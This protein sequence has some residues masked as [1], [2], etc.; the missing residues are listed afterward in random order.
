MDR[1]IGF[2]FG[3]V[4]RAALMA[5]TLMGVATAASA[6]TASPAAPSGNPVSPSSG[7]IA[8]FYGNIAPF[9]GNISPFYGNIQPF[10]GNIQPFSGN[11][12]PFFGNISPF[13]GNIQPFWG[14]IN[15]YGMVSGAAS[16]GAKTFWGSLTPYVG[17]FDPSFTA[18]PSYASVAQFRGQMG[19]TWNQLY[20]SWA[21]FQASPTAANYQAVANLINAQL[22]A[23]SQA[24]FGA[25][26]RAKT[27]LS[28]DSGFVAPMLAKYHIDPSDLASLQANSVANLA[29]F[30][31][32]WNDQLMQYSGVNQVDYWMK[33]DNWSPALTQ[34]QGSAVRATVGLLDFTV[35]N[36]VTV[37]KNLIWYSGVSSFTNGHGADVASLISAAPTGQ[38]VMGIAPGA[39]VVAY[40]PFDSSGTTNWA[41]VQT[42]V[43]ALA[44]HGAGVINASLGVPN[45]TLDQGWNGVLSDPTVQA[46]TRNTILVV[47]AGNGG[48][49]QTQNIVWNGANA[50][51]IVVGSVGITGQ[52]SSFS[53]T[54][55]NACLTN[56]AGFCTDYLK[57]HFIVAPG[58]MILVSNDSGGVMRV[59]G[60]SFAA[61]QVAGAIALLQGRW[62]WLVQYPQETAGVILQTAT[63]M[64]TSPGSDP[65]YGVGMLNVQA[66]QSPLNYNNLTWYALSGSRWTQQSVNQV[67]SVGRMTNTT[68]WNAA[69]LYFT[70]FERVGRTFRDF[71]I[72][73]SSSLVGQSVTNMAGYSNVF[74]QYLLTEFQTW[75]QQPHFAGFTQGAAVANPWGVDLTMRLSPNVARAGFVQTAAPYG[76][77]LTLTGEHDRL[78]FGAVGG[79]TA[80]GGV[81]G[82]AQSDYDT[83]RGGANPFLGLAAGGGYFNWSKS[84]GGRL[85]VAVG[86]TQRNDL[87]DPTMFS[88]IIGS[89]AEHYQAEAANLSASYQVAR[90]LTL[91]IAT[92]RLKENSGL[93]GVQSRAQGDLAG[94]SVTNAVTLGADINLGGSLQLSLS[95][96][97][98]VTK[99]SDG[100]SLRTGEGGVVSSAYAAALAKSDLFSSGDRLRLSVSQPL[101]VDRGTV[102]FAGVGVVDRQ[103]GTLGVT[104]QFANITSPT[105]PYS[106]ELLYERPVFSR[107]ATLG[108]YGRV[109]RLAGDP[110][111]GRYG[112][113][114]QFRLTF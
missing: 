21:N 105:K 41:D 99:T 22:I 48:V 4:S 17:P 11:I 14:D 6:Q 63:K 46:A 88:N 107:A 90:P 113:G 110:S 111:S 93:L 38:G 73:L 86:L 1:S 5:A 62:P 12:Q 40:N 68:A 3:R 83:A 43:T 60:T 19:P 51:L 10:Y 39:R 24:T 101:H 82:F 9:Y 67:I 102:D 94:G 37:Q 33:L 18:A 27:G 52:I 16:P 89:A 30:F 2:K 56:T 13:Y 65:V 76:V 50:P 45:M 20:A 81:T 31:L 78:D 55:G 112:A 77:A 47:A 100:A 23:P 42:G 26:F 96:T 75:A 70:A 97:R 98:G 103:T 25:A 72:P 80:L 91:M 109:E 44:S 61:P 36:D 15:P 59:S 53:N 95:G 28:F 8:P 34:Q 106:A 74:Q 29:M 85:S 58:E 84:L 7:N 57:N 54:P 114:G 87:R 64:G 79:A 71:E 108:F 32:E 104:H 66:S 92:T 49:S 35:Q 69:G